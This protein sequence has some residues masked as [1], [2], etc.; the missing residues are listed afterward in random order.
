MAAV[1]DASA[2]VAGAAVVALVSGIRIWTAV[3]VFALVYFA[4]STAWKGQSFATWWLGGDAKRKLP[5]RARLSSR[6]WLP[7][8]PALLRTLFR[9]SGTTTGGTRTIPRRT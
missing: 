4:V 9:E 8:A 2:V 6:D 1:A 5:V 3:G 7:R